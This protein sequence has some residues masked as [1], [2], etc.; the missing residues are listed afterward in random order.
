MKQNPFTDQNPVR[1]TGQDNILKPDILLVEDNK[2]I[3]DFISREIAAIT[4]CVRR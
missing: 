1:A 3:L 4:W 2:E